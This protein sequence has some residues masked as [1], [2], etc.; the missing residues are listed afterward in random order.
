MP[1]VNKGSCN[2][3]RAL[4]KK[5]EEGNEQSSQTVGPSH[6]SHGARA[7]TK[8]VVGA[9]AR[10]EAGAQHR[11]RERAGGGAGDQGLQIPCG[12]AKE[13]RKG[14]EAEEA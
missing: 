9:G 13:E 3:S 5:R 12:L 6:L 14:E 8:A 2:S 10:D 7:G 4:P 11:V 1:T